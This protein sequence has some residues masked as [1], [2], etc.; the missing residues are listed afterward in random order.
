MNLKKRG[1]ALLMCICMIMTLLP[2]AAFADDAAVVYGQYTDDG[3]AEDPSADGT[4]TSDNITISKTAEP[5]SGEADTYRI[6][7]SVTTTTTTEQVPPGSAA[8]VLVMDVS[9]SMDFCAECGADEKHYKGCTYE[10]DVKSSQSRL[11]SAKAAANSFLDSYGGTASESGN[12]RYVA[13]VT[14]ESTS[15]IACGWTDV[16]TSSGLT[17]VKNVISR[18]KA[19]GGTNLDAGLQSAAALLASDAVN[20][21]TSKNVIAL[22]DGQPTFYGNGIEAHGY[23][24]CPDT[25][26]ATAASAAKVRALADVY[27]VCFG[28]ANELCWEKG[29]V[30]EWGFLG[31][32]ETHSSNGP[33][34]GAFLR[35]SIATSAML[36]LS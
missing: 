13:I 7:L 30:H 14:F 29:S 19:D 9:G 31:P 10:G 2:V 1:L 20:G 25:N 5:V 21:V 35:D 12:G 27:T 26:N 24:G 18:L 4:V 32:S 3:W 17:K 33:T 36:S 34:V 22:T 16:S 23:Y 15:S 6:N 28:V 8:T 11:T